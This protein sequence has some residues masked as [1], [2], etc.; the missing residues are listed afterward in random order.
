MNKGTK[1]F[2]LGLV[3]VSCQQTQIDYALLS[4]K[5]ENPVSN[6]ISIR[7]DEF[8]QNI[9]VEDDGSFSDTLRIKEGYYTFS[10][11]ERTTFYLKPGENIYMTIDTEAFDETASYEGTGAE[12]NNYLAK[13]YLLDEEVSGSYKEM[14]LLDEKAFVSKSSEINATL[15]QHLTETE[16]M[17]ENFFGK[18]QKGINYENLSRIQAYEDAHAYYAGEDDFKVSETF[19]EP[20]ATVDFD[21]AKDFDEIPAYKG[22][23]RSYYLN[24]SSITN[25]P[26]ALLAAINTIRQLKSENIKHALAE[27]LTSFYMSPN[28]DNLEDVY[29]GILAMVTDEE[30][31]GEI[32]EKYDKISK[33]V[34]GNPSPQFEYPNPDSTFFSLEDLKGKFV[35]ID[36]WATWCG[37]CLR[38]IPALKEMEVVYSQKNVQF[39]SISIDRRRDYEK[40]QNMIVE[41]Q[42]GGLQLF[43][44]DDWN[45]TIVKD[46]AIEGIPRFILL[47]RDG[48]IVSADAPRPSSPK[49]AE[50]LDD[51]IEKSELLAS[52]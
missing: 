36:I 37:P 2:A 39:V 43:A 12:R 33:L 1:M 23:V 5:V 14:M 30:Q 6:N 48:N 11:G 19:K 13:K 7:G 45:S 4:G 15:L 52:K 17:E 26:D 38:E 18:E 49:L 31:K 22:L 47:D 25:D 50:M 35:Y 28:V 8:S 34:K 29:K 9:D 27:P 40:W 20:L 32:T 21:N 10:H 42:L 16:G 24:Y 44:E 41:K 46:Y 3:M 51:L